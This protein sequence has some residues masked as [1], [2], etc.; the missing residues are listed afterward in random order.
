MVAAIST[1]TGSVGALEEVSRSAS[2]SVGSWLREHEGYRGTFVSVD[3]AAGKARRLMT[4]WD[5]AA[6][7]DR[8]REFRGA[9]RDQL[10]AIAGMAV[11]EFEVLDVLACEVVQDADEPAA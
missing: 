7:E 11:V 10:A 9:M 6:D 2:E 3:L 8:A 1:L 4:L 5:S